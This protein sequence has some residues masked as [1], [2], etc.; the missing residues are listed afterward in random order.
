MFEA[1]IIFAFL[2]MISW[3]F[4][5]FFIQ[6]TTR[7]VGD[8]E[9]LA[10][11][12]IIG[13]L[14]L[15]TLVANDFELLFYIPNMLLLLFL[16]LTTFIIG[17]LDFEALKKGKLCIIDV[18]LEIELP[19]TIALSFIFFRES[20]SAVQLFITSLVFIGIMLIATKCF[21]KKHFK[22]ERGVFM[23]IIAAIG[24]GL[25]NFL[26]ATSSKSISPLMAVW[27]PWVIFTILC[28][29]VIARRERVPK[30]I[31]NFKKF[32]MLILAM[33]I[34]DT[35]AWLFYALA[36]LKNEVSITTAI[37]ESY[38]AIAIILGS[39][40]NKEKI[41][42]HQYVGAGLALTASIVLAMSVSF[43]VS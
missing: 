6:R 22:I 10:F 21:N 13:S 42:W 41:N 30:L 9:A 26:T 8:L 32:K 2:A 19:V 7:K 37:T 4:G 15:L 39:L 33:G 16:G 40:E 18:V 11:I 31:S 3:G 28:L 29:I 20:L 36:V 43:P 12:G 23:A 27:F 14:G 25:I 24:M 1:S 38:P 35:L 34:F 17:V 5:D